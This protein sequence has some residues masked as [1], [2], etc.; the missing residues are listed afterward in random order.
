MSK[1]KSTREGVTRPR[2][3][4]SIDIENTLDT[5][6]DCISQEKCANGYVVKELNEERMFQIE[7]Q[8][9]TRQD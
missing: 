2:E 9:V 1:D 8:T 7:Y 3:K 5:Q 6:T 4:Q